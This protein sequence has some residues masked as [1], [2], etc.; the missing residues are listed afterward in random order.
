MYFKIRGWWK[1]KKII[2]HILAVTE[3][4]ELEIYQDSTWFYLNPWA[5][6]SWC[7]IKR[8][9][10]FYFKEYL[11][12]SYDLSKVKTLD[13]ENSEKKLFQVC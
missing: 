11:L 12:K 3:Y 1:L 7:N 9:N 4:L 13:K 8:F 6:R 2:K 5:K 10:I